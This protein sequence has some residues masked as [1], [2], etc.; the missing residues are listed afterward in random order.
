MGVTGNLIEEFRDLTSYV[1]PRLEHMSNVSQAQML[2]TRDS[3]YM[4]DEQPTR[5]VEKETQKEIEE[6][7]QR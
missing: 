4:I 1:L 3:Q 6:E 5:A 7:E 2:T